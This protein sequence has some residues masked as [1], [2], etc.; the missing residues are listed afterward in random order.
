MSETHIVAHHG[1]VFFVDDGLADNDSGSAVGSALWHDDDEDVA[2]PRS[3][4]LSI[5]DLYVGVGRNI[6][7]WKAQSTQTKRNMSGSFE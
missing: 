2:T 6:L 7:G 3:L 4:E 5:F 1:G